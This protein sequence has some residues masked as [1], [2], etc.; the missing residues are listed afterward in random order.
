[1]PGVTG[2]Q[3][4]GTPVTIP[5]VG[6]VNINA[7]GSYSFTPEPGYDGAIPLITYTV[8]DGNGGTDTSTLALTMVPVNDPPVDPDDTN[9]VTEDTTLT[10]DAAN[11]LLNNATDP[12]GDPLTIT[13]FTVPGITGTQTVG[14]P[15]AIAGVGS[16]TINADG[17]Y[18]FTPEANYTGAI[19]VITYTVSDGNGGTDTST[20]TLTMVPVNDPPVDPDDRNSVTEDTP[21][22]VDAA[23][24]LLNGATDPEGD[25]LTHHR[26]HRARRHRHADAGH[27]RDHP[28]RG[29][30]QHQP[31]RQLQLHA[32]A[33]LRRC[34]PGDHVHGERRQRR[35]GHVHAGADHGAGER[36]TGGWR[37]DQHGHGRHD[38][39]GGRW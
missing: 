26:L 35:H 14:T 4:P 16:V 9:T 39:D 2:T 22:T 25:P 27:A 8:S 5:G 7:D 33:W 20:L 28:R 21:L 31:G 32:R 17:S 13:G 18:S 23:N 29:L 37:R 38:A 34:D 19:P 24:G 30:G 12:E 10:V 1:M 6:E 36:P 3:T 11:G 15:V